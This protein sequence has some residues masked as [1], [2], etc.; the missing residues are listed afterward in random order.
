MNYQK[1]LLTTCRN[2]SLIFNLITALFGK[3][4][5]LTA[6]VKYFLWLVPHKCPMSGKKE[7]L[8]YKQVLERPYL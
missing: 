1:I 6:L 4:S 2:S 3:L 8:K 5:Q 7:R